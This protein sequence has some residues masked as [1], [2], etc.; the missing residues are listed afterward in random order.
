MGKR[1][2]SLTRSLLW[3]T[4][5]TQEDDVA[6]GSCGIALQLGLG[7]CS[8]SFLLCFW[9]CSAVCTWLNGGMRQVGWNLLGHRLCLAKG[10][11]SVTVLKT[12]LGHSS[13]V[14]S[15]CLS[16]LMLCYIAFLQCNGMKWLWVHAGF[17]FLRTRAI[18]ET[19]G[20][21]FSMRYT[22]F[23]LTPFSFI[24]VVWVMA[25]IIEGL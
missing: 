5:L 22:V 15:R 12:V 19:Q 9:H 20:Q 13:G 14:S 17:F 24:S 4:G 1:F 2:A 16:A 25:H 11:W 6:R 18:S 21:F 10:H 8:L 23:R 3:R 7:S